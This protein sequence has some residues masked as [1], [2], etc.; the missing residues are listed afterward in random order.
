MSGMKWL[1]GYRLGF[2][3]LLNN[4]LYANAMYCEETIQNA[5]LI[6]QQFIKG[7]DRSFSKM[8][9]IKNLFW[10]YIINNYILC[11]LMEYNVHA[12]VLPMHL[13]TWAIVGANIERNYTCSFQETELL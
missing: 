9:V 6:I 12:V 11:W 8:V 13:G 2:E 10:L 5:F 4:M 7:V 1:L 3:S